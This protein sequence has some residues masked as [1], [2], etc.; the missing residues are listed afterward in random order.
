[1]NLVGYMKH[2][3]SRNS[4]VE[5]NTSSHLHTQGNPPDAV[6][7][8]IGTS[9]SISTLHHDPYE[10]L[11]AVIRGRKHFTLYPPTDLYWLE[12]KFYKKAHYERYDT[13]QSTIDQDGLNLKIDDHFI[14]VPENHEVPWFDHDEEQLKQRPY[15]NPL[16]VSLEP[17]ELLYLPSLWFHRVE[18]D[19]P[20]TIACNFWYDMQYDIKW[21][22][23]QFMSNMIKQKC[24]T[25]EE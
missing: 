10:N 8:W 7:L 5:L 12:Q 20:L 21:N 22:Y 24:R 16:K 11:Y 13:L 3:V 19:S 1:M 14:I 17:G 25:E 15:L 23:Y 18:Q 4:I 6:N 2:S 9:K